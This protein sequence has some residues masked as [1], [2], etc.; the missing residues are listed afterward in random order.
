MT[1][2]PLSLVVITQDAA[3]QLPNCLTSVP[4]A[5]EILVVDSG[6]RDATTT[7]AETHGA[8]VVHQAWL[9]FGPQKRFAVQEAQHDWVLCLDADE[10]L[11][12]AL[13]QAIEHELSTPRFTAYRFARRNR[14]LG[15]W[16][17]HGE[18]Y[19]DW[20]LRL[21]HRNHAQWRTDPI[22][23]GV[24]AQGKVGTLTGDLLH[25]SAQT[26]ESYLAKQNRYTSLQ[27]ERLIAA[28]KRPGAARIVL[29]PLLRFFKFYLLR[30]GFLDGTP[31]LVHIL[32]G[33]FN[34]F[35]KYAKAREGWI[36]QPAPRVNNP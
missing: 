6:S 15:R 14:F 5:D 2:L 3:T 24:E 13:R 26:L 19:P 30:L 21:F 9:G 12:P 17:R 18:G 16:L 33:C 27:A 35:C 10:S 36:Q 25:E 11:S 31:G 8:R 34:S 32:I 28:G 23:E 20:Q 29:S 4:F 22:H 1:R 7:I